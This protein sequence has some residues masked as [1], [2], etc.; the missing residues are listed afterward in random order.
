MF[1]LP[2]IS[3]FYFLLLPVILLLGLVIWQRTRYEMSREDNKR[4]LQ[5]SRRIYEI[6]LEDPNFETVVQKIA[7]TIPAELKFGTGVLAILNESNGTIKRVAASQTPEAERAIMLLARMSIRFS[8]MEI[9]VND[10]SNLMARSLREKKSFAT[11]DV[12]DVLGPVVTKEQAQRVQ[13]VMSTKTTF[14]YPILMHDRPLGVFI[15]ST[16]KRK[17]KISEYEMEVL[18]NF[19]NL[20]GISLQNAKLFTSLK[21]TTDQLTLANQK[22]KEL[23][24]L[25]D[26]FVSVASHELRTPMT[27]IRSYAWMAL[28]RSDVPLSKTLQKYVVRILMST[29]RLINMVN[30]MLNVSRI[31]SGRI[32]INP[33]PVDILSLV[34]DII[35]EVYFSKFEEKH[36]EFVVLEQLIPK[37]FADPDKLRQVLLNLVGNSMK[38]TPDGGKI[39]FGFF[40]DGNTVEISVSD[41]GVGISQEDISKLFH[42]FSRLDTSYVAAATSGGTGLGLY[43]SKSLVALMRGKITVYSEGVGKGTTFKI[44]LPAASPGILRN[45]EKYKVKPVGEAKALEPVAL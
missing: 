4:I 44:T 36:I 38:F 28:N 20:V 22:L 16:K 11:N 21:S 35:D 24:Q 30:D 25:K 23:D 37:V 27:A 29:E 12:Y 3:G 45:A 33:E 43:I 1:D 41:T 13:E 8:G 15:A 34:K 26:E 9:S 17:S 7:N 10:R 2:F 14:V 31:E 6:L 40:S 42:K 18:A 19:V 39:T 5:S 32:E